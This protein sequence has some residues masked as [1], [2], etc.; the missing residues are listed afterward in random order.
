MAHCDSPSDTPARTTNPRLPADAETEQT[1]AGTLVYRPTADGLGRRLAGFLE[2][3]EDWGAMRD[4]LLRRG[5][6]VGAIY[7]KPVYR[8][9]T[10]TPRD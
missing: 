2:A 6:D 4:E 3:V 7:H 1:N 8:R 9:P 10:A 5:K